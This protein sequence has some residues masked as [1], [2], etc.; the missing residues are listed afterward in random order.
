MLRAERLSAAEART[1]LQADV[2][3]QRLVQSQAQR[4][5]AETHALPPRWQQVGQLAADVGLLALDDTT[6]A[7]LFA[8]LARLVAVPDPVATLERLLGAAEGVPGT[9]VDGM[10]PAAHGVA[11]DGASGTIVH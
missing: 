10:A 3:R 8:T 9:A 1:R 6:L 5:A 4:R 7:K 2:Q 11:P